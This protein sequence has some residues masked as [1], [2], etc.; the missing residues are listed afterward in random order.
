MDICDVEDKRGVT[1]VDYVLM[2]GGGGGVK[3]QTYLTQELHNWNEIGV[4]LK[5]R[6]AVFNTLW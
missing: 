6:F 3:V 2:D 5:C 1:H 4:L